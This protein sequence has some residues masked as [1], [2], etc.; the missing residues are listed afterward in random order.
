MN[1]KKM[2]GREG[3]ERKGDRARGEIFFGEGISCMCFFSFFFIRGSNRACG[4]S[5]EV[6]RDAGPDRTGGNCIAVDRPIP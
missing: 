6:R 5:H 3:T 1:L 2:L 4:A